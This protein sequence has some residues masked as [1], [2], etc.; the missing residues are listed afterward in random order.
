MTLF[1]QYPYLCVS[2][3]AVPSCLHSLFP[4]G[5]RGMLQFFVR[6]WDAGVIFGSQQ[7][8]CVIGSVVIQSWLSSLLNSQCADQAGPVWSDPNSLDAEGAVVRPGAETY[9]S[10]ILLLSDLYLINTYPSEKNPNT[11]SVRNAHVRGQVESTSLYW[12]Q[13]KHFLICELGLKYIF[14]NRYDDKKCSWWCRTFPAKWR[15]HLLWS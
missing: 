15:R 3:W 2:K 11:I 10:L 13:I 9:P 7:W 6:V 14:C 4:A 5:G 12:K 1:L 8:E